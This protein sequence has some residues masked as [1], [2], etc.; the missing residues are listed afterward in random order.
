MYL[1]MKR[2]PSYKEIE[3]EEEEESLEKN[4]L[5]SQSINIE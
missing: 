2:S 5:I 1:Q 3:H 4:I